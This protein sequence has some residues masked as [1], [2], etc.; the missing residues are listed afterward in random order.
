MTTSISFASAPVAT[1]SFVPAV[2][3][4]IAQT[5]RLL[6]RIK[7]IRNASIAPGTRK[8]RGVSVVDKTVLGDKIV[9]RR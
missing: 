6:S 3:T 4:M 8:G 9:S 7:Q 2:V 5:P 1:H